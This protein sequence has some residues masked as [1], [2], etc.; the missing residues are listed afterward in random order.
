M[1]NLDFLVYTDSKSLTKQ[2]FLLPNPGMCLRAGCQL[3]SAAE[4]ELTT[5][6]NCS[7]KQV[8]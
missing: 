8:H 7:E 5:G 3:I 2:V 6:S 1:Q 4:K